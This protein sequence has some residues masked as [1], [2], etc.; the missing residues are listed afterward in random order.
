M[1]PGEPLITLTT[2]FGARDSYVAQMKGVMLGINPRARF[3]DVT[4]DIPPQSILRAALMLP[5]VVDTFPE[6]TFHLIVVD[7]GVGS[8]REILAAEIAGHH[9]IAPDNGLLDPLCQIHTPQRQFKLT[10]GPYWRGNISSTFHGRD[11]MA[12]AIAHWSRG[13]A[14]EE[15]G[16]S[17]ERPPRTLFL[18]TPEITENEIRGTILYADHFGNL[19][20]NIR[21]EDLAADDDELLIRLESEGRLKFSANGIQHTYAAVALGEGLAL[22]GSHGYLEVGVNGGSAAQAFDVKSGATLIV[23]ISK[24]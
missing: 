8:T 23:E 4:H 14:L 21:R 10:P 3:I 24:S 11:I 15:L 19:V 7:P 1:K 20:S 16:E 5:E 12:P 22:W 18:P 13:V 17:L 2:D 9:F 6:G